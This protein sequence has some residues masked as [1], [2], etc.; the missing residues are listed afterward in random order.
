MNAER[1]GVR[2]LRNIEPLAGGLPAKLEQ[3]LRADG[4]DY[5]GT[6]AIWN[7]PLPQSDRQ[8]PFPSAYHTENP[9]LEALQRPHCPCTSNLGSVPDTAGLRS[10]A[11]AVALTPSIRL[12]SS[13]EEPP[14]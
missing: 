8:A 12:P 3:P 9:S 14:C 11:S 4:L 1:C 6:A 2:I 13:K 7:A 10:L 5:G